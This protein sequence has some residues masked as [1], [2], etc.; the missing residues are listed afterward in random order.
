MHAIHEGVLFVFAPRNS[1][2][3]PFGSQRSH[4]PCTLYTQK[5]NIKEICALLCLLCIDFIL[6]DGDMNKEA[7][8]RCGAC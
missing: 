3:G 6:V 5:V 7:L 8:E 2:H 1:Y 4:Q